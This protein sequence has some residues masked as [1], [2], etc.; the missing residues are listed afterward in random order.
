MEVQLSL[1]G[2]PSPS[3]F[4]EI[5]DFLSAPEEREL[6][7]AF[8]TIDWQLVRMH[9][10]TAKRRV[11]HYGY[12]Y[13]YE[14]WKVQPTDPAP[15][16]LQPFIARAAPLMGAREEE[17]A[18]ILISDYPPGAGI[19]WHRDAPM[20]GDAVFGFSLKSACTMKFRRKQGDGFEIFKADLQPRDA[21]II[22]GPCRRDWQHSISPVKSERFSVTF[23][24]L[25]EGHKAGNS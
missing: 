3:G 8:A 25:K 6:I 16:F 14:S 11:K 13:G 12:D 20:F 22:S 24:T 4:K 15:E 18:E 9:G 19:G 7:A 23:R 1:L 21:Y 5:P 2:E 10:V 17:I